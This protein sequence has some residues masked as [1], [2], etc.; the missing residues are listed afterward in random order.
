MICTFNVTHLIVYDAIVL[1]N[2][3]PA[4]DLDKIF[5]MAMLSIL[6]NQIDFYCSQADF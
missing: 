4:C 2:F 6:I 5:I 3:N 1:V